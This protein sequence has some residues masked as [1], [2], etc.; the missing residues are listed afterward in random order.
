MEAY[1]FFFLFLILLSFRI[2]FSFILLTI[3]LLVFLI[4]RFSLSFRCLGR[5]DYLLR[6]SGFDFRFII[7]TSSPSSGFRGKQPSLGLRFGLGLDL[8]TNQFLQSG[9]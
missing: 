5:L 6:G 1:L 4:L 3:I 2:R 7:R 8:D 9:S